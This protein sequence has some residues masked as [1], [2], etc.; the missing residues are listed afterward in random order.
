MKYPSTLRVCFLFLTFITFGLFGNSH[1]QAQSQKNSISSANADNVEKIRA[2]PSV[3]FRIENTLTPPTEFFEYLE[4]KGI[5]PPNMEQVS[6]GEFH[7]YDLPSNRLCT[8]EFKGNGPALLGVTTADLSKIQRYILGNGA[9]EPDRII[10][11]DANGSGTVT[12]ADLVDIRKVLLGKTPIF[13]S[14]VSWKFVPAF[15]E[16]YYTGTTIDLGT[17]KAIK[18]GHVN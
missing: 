17:I 3:I 14:G 11:A 8:I 9:L 4:I 7:I 16:F 5:P 18:I 15:S 2:A 1:V 13:G 10:A 6:P 12:A